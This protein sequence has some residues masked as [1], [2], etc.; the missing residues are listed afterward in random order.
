M[1]TF[2]GSGFAE[3]DRLATLFRRTRELLHE[4]A[5]TGELPPDA[6]DVIAHEAL[7]HVE[8]IEQGFRVS[9]RASAVE[10]AELRT[11]IARAG[12]NTSEPTTSAEAR[13]ALIETMHDLALTS[14][15]HA[16]IVAAPIRYLAALEHA[17]LVFALLPTTAAHEVNFP[18]GRR[19]YADIWPPRGA[20]E[21]ADRIEELERNLWTVATQ[22]R[23]RISDGSYRRT[24]GFF[25]T[26]ARM[27]GHGFQAA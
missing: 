22:R 19:T 18:L 16:E 24:Y 3:F 8:D 6:A 10:I 1:Q 7:P 12:L 15:A 9:L 11:L 20:A 13:A 25:D 17:R 23:P 2:D 21:L 4:F 5:A 26:A 14:T 27:S